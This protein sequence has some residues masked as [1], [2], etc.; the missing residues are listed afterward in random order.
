MRLTRWFALA[1]LL[2]ASTLFAQER[3][4]EISVFASDLGYTES[5]AT[6]SNVSGGVGVA[7]NQWWTSRISTE[8]GVTMEKHFSFRDAQQTRVYTYPVDFLAQYHFRNQSR[9]QPYFGVGA[10][11]GD[12]VAAEINGGVMFLITP[13]LGLKLDGKRFGSETDEF[14]DSLTKFSIGLGW[15][16]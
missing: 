13:Q 2:S 6:G 16:F 1:L 5:A 14:H 3:R 11:A 7:L 8:L 10:R 12:R 9:W 15:R 4:T